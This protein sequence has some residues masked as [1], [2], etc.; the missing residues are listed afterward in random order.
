V[1]EIPVENLIRA[2]RTVAPDDPIGRAAEALRV[3]GLTEL[4]V[5]SAGQVAGVVTE[6]AILNAFT[7]G[8]PK[9][10]MEQ[11]V[12]T[13]ISDRAVC[14]SRH[15]PVSRVAEVMKEHGLQV[16]SVVS[17]F[18]Y[19]MGIVTRSDIASMLSLTMRPPVVAGLATP[20]GVY[21]TTGNIRAGVGDLGLFLAGAFMVLMMF[22]A[23]WIVL[24][25]AWLAQEFGHIPLWTAVYLPPKEGAGL[26]WLTA[27]GYVIRFAALPI[28][29]LLIRLLPLSGYHAAEHQVV[30]AIE[31]GEPLK[32]EY[33]GMMPRVHPRCGTNI[34]A[35]VILLLMMAQIFSMETAVLITVFV[36]VFAWRVIGGYFQQYV[37]TKPPSRKQIESG[38]RAGES[39]LDKYR[40]DP[41]HRVTGWRRIWNTGMP[42]VM[43]GASAAITL[44]EI[45]Y[46]SP[47]SFF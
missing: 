21:L 8:D 6:A 19:L 47:P 26:S 37:T 1:H 10:A 30:H 44:G 41:G 33:V 16:V 18:G 45:L 27:A 40:Q 5:I 2:V 12:R 25:I 43:I 14:V 7:A 39:L 20:L 15:M 22:A 31:N 4:P 32:P 28:W 34:F 9:T 38:I 17:E 42:Q 35:G 46:F 29:M 24:G 3:S 36:L 23:S 11:P 13:I